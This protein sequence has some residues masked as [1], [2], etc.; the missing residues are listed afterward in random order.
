MLGF[1]IQF[2]WAGWWLEGFKHFIQWESDVLVCPTLHL[3]CRVLILIC[4]APAFSP[5]SSF[6]LVPQLIIL[7]TNNF[8]HHFF[9]IL[10]MFFFDLILHF[11]LQHEFEVITEGVVI[12][13][14]GWDDS[15]I[16]RPHLQCHSTVTA[17]PPRID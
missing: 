7:S 5:H 4:R 14:K 8:T 11:Y 10:C 1:K 2:Y 12:K 15:I 6:C 9:F 16:M 13:S 3:H 17:Q